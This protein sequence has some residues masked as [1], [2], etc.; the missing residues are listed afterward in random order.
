M[1]RI[2]NQIITI[3]SGVTVAMDKRIVTVTGPKGVL[4][5]TVP[6]KINVDIKDSVVTVSRVS[7]DKK[8][9][10]NHGTTRAHIQNMVTGVTTGWTK[11]LEIRGTGY[12][13][14]GG[15]DKLTITAGYIHPVIMTAVD[16]VTFKVSDDSSKVI[17]S[18]I[19]KVFVG[20][21]ASNIRKVR[22]PEPYKGKG[23]RYLN[24]FIKLKA[25][26]TAKT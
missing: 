3:P 2:G 17:V 7:E 11:E 22:T 16:G 20:Q 21:A 13:F 25:G 23:I 4:T 8:V 10:A 5:L 24:E 15:N 9:K 19:N 1:S 14:A 6:F 26:K 12:K 18:G